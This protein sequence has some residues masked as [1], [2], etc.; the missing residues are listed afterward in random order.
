MSHECE[1][2]IF[3]QVSLTQLSGS[4]LNFIQYTI[5]RVILGNFRLKTSLIFP[6]TFHITKLETFSRLF[7]R[8]FELEIKTKIFLSFLCGAIF[9]S[10]AIL[11]NDLF[12][13]PI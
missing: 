7:T 8:P 3:Y 13:N 10:I 11:R 1:L 9:I 4:V 6:S 5:S 12:E 2:R